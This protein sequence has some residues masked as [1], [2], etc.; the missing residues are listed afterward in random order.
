M[1]ETQIRLYDIEYDTDGEDFD[2][3]DIE[4]LELPEEITTTLE[5][6]GWDGEENM[7]EFVSEYA[8]DY[9]SDQFGWLVKSL[10]FKIIKET[11]E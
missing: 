9:V 11:E 7:E 8:A 4:D 3:A 6:M 1:T 5:E 10:S 2:P